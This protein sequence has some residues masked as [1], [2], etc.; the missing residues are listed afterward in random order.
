ML[1]FE[2]HN[3]TKIIFG[4][5]RIKET[6]S[7][8][9]NLANH[10][11][12]IVGG[13]SVR[14]NGILDIVMQSIQDQNIQ[15][16]LLEG[17]QPNPLLSKVEEGI[18][19]ARDKKVDVIVAL[20]GGSVMDTGKAIAA[21]TLLKQGNVWDFFIGKQQID[22]ALPVV[23]IPTLA[24]SGSEMNGYM[25]ITNKKTGHK[26]ATGSPYLYPKFSILDPVTTF[27]VPPNYTAYG[28]LDAICHLLEPYFNGPYPYTPVQDGIAE[29]L[30]KAIMDNTLASIASPHDYDSRASLMWGA[31]LALCGLTKAGVGDHFFPVH[32][33]E[34]GISAIFD[35]PHGAGLA[36]LLPGWMKWRAKSQPDKIIQLG[37]N[38]FNLEKPVEVVDV[39][40][41]FVKWL[42]KA[43]CPTNL[44]DLNIT[45]DELEKIADNV[46][47]QI[48]LS[49][50]DPPYSKENVLKIL[51]YG[52]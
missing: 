50:M 27:T 13:G 39:I 40:N 52:L 46:S 20:G 4:K 42:K 35:V 31:T 37:E 14:K 25:V 15:I 23:A 21:G 9:K 8:L 44:S 36:A 41:A 3:P 1:K 47:A 51:K 45:E 2:F 32:V 11:L 19:I 33:I 5:D 6:G 10:I 43:G 18:D 34:H 49:K 29:G 38:V 48:K 7:L 12:L 28:G 17:V 30:I 22:K 16:E 24:A 26:F